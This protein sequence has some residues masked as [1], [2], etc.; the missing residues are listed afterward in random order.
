M[1]E[2]DTSMYKTLAPEQA[3]PVKRM[4][5]MAGI[6]NTLMQSQLMQNQNVQQQMQNRL[7]GG[8][9]SMGQ[10]YSDAVDPDTGMM[11]TN[12]LQGSTASDPKTNFMMPEVVKFG[13]DI[14]APVTTYGP[15]GQAYYTSRQNLQNQIA[16]HEHQKMTDHLDT[17]ENTLDGLYQKQDLDLKD[18]VEATGDL[19]ANGNMKPQEAAMAFAKMPGGA[20]GSANSEQLRQWVGGFKNQIAQ[21]RAQFN[22]T[23]GAQPAQAPMAAPPPGVITASDNAAMG[24]SGAMNEMN[25]EVAEAP[26][27]IFQRQKALE[28]LD[29]TTIGP[30]KE[31]TNKAAKFVISFLP[32]GWDKAIPGVDKNSSAYFDEA[33]KYM[34]QVMIS[35]AGGMGGAATAD[36]LAAAASGSPNTSLLN[37]TAQDLIKTDIGLER[38]GMA[39]QNAWNHSGQS[40]D[41]FN[42]W[43]SQWNDQIDPRAF[44]ADH[45]DVSKIK[46]MTDGMKPG[47]KDKFFKTYDMAIQSGLLEEPK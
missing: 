13:Q 9:L 22:Q 47:E 41:K 2:V 39:M 20:D 7:T 36:K 40:P 11:D 4:Q 27:R 6:R 24:A 16:P 21:T 23:H 31:T 42:Q 43:R 38:M 32:D 35:R 17:M 3:D 34:T 44:M 30:G 12:K 33:K 45:M 29:Q 37:A 8:V 15:N 28:A 25:S 46:K 19:V 14:N 26:T 5:E 18:V 10:H 1:T